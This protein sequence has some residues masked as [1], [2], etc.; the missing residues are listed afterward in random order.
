M[1]YFSEEISVGSSLGDP[2]PNEPKGLAYTINISPKDY[3]MKEGVWGVLKPDDQHKFLKRIHKHGF[4]KMEDYID[5]H[6][7]D[8]NSNKVCFEFT[9]SGELHSHGYYI[10]K[11]KYTGYKRYEVLLSKSLKELLPKSNYNVIVK[12]MENYDKWN[13]Y[14]TKDLDKSG[15]K[16]YIANYCEVTYKDILWYMENPIKENK[17]K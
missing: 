8:Y 5:I 16:E 15:Y 12:V 2:T 9:K 4:L 6:N 7:E 1:K 11:D 3:V 14:I 13:K 17:E 10:L